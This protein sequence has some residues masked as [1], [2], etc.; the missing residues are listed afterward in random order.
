MSA[1]G[2]AIFRS[3]CYAEGLSK[4][5]VTASVGAADGLATE[6]RYTTRVL[7]GVARGVAEAVQGDQAGLGR[8]GAIVA[9]VTATAAGYAAGT[10]QRYGGRPTRTE[11]GRPHDHRPAA[12]RADPH[13]PR[14]RPA[15]GDRQPELAVPPGAFVAQLGYLHDAG[16]QTVTAGILAEFMNGG[17]ERLPDR[18]VVLTFDDGFE[19]FHRLALPLL[20]QYGFTAS[21]YITTGWVQDACSLS[22]GRLG[23]TPSWCQISEAAGRRQRES[24]AHSHT[25][26]QL[27]Q[28]PRQR[29]PRR[30]GRRQGACSRTGSASPMHRTGVPVR[31]L[32]R[33]G[34]R[35]GAGVG[36]EYACVVGNAMCPARNQTRWRCPA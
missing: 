12:A 7:P 13:V 25:H 20:A 2:S 19:D 31:V 1:A 24:A 10:V 8:A 26:P 34:A 11:W 22:A 27:D 21:L 32:E 6:R 30:A 14:D 15:D 16:F 17:S 3:R 36:H 4:A 29:P 5:Q 28:L 33:R 18:A 9:G 23:W 35:G